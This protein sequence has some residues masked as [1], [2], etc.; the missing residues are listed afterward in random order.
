MKRQRVKKNRM[1]KVL[2][3]V[4]AS[5]ILCAGVPEMGT[6]AGKMSRTMNWVAYAVTITN[7]WSEPGY[8]N[9]NTLKVRSGANNSGT[10]LAARATDVTAAPAKQ[11]IGN[12]KTK[13]A[14]AWHFAKKSGKTVQ[15]KIYYRNKGSNYSY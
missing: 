12:S 2:A 1:K 4:M 7:S 3:T 13:S 11:A 10:L 5:A 6:D 14:E 9:C 15:L 8:G